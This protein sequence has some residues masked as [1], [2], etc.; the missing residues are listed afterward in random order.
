[1]STKTIHMGF[2]WPYTD[3]FSV[4][5]V[6]CFSVSKIDTTNSIKNVLK[7]EDVS[8]WR[9]KRRRFIYLKRSTIAN[10]KTFSKSSFVA[11]PINFM[12]RV[13]PGI[14]WPTDAVWRHKS[15]S[16][17]THIIYRCL[18]TPSHYGSRH[19]RIISNVSW[20][21]SQISPQ[22]HQPSMIKLS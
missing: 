13:T 14:M 21:S 11:F 15:G 22:T 8:Y 1:M 19:W 4:T 17:L 16:I 3:V 10:W 9:F 7:P 5:S 20:H 18:T 2:I 6:V 12:E